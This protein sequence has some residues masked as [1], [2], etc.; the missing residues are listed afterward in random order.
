MTIVNGFQP[1]TIITKRSILYFAAV[2]DPSLSMC[3]RLYSWYLAITALVAS[4]VMANEIRPP[5]LLVA[6]KYR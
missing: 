6:N 4:M 5:L 3:L 1:L 2:L